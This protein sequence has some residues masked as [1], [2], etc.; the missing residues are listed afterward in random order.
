MWGRFVNFP[1]PYDYGVG[2][3]TTAG[4]QIRRHNFFRHRKP[5]ARQARG[6][7]HEAKKSR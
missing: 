5:A 3:E 2:G 6:A 1:A 4:W 7:R